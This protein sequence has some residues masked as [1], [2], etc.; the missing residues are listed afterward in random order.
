[1]RNIFKIILIFTFG[2]A[3]AVLDNAAAR[4]TLNGRGI[5]YAFRKE[6]RIGE[7]FRKG[8]DGFLACHIVVRTKEGSLAEVQTC[9]QTC[10][11][12]VD[13]HSFV[14][15]GCFLG[16]APALADSVIGRETL[17]GRNVG[18]VFRKEARSGEGFQACHVV[19]RTKEGS[20]AEMQT[21]EQTCNARVD[22]H[23][24]VFS[25]CLRW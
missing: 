23:S 19:V 21:C 11:R 22:G 13:G 12:R 9:E 16:A 2:G 15:S 18:D 6:A 3:P 8:G 20:L 4:E 7:G 14:K 5:G 25:G 24:F 10:N 17:N 1:M